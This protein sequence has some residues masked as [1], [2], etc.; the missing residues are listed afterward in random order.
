MPITFLLSLLGGIL[1][2]KVSQ[3]VFYV[4]FFLII[5]ITILN[6]QTRAMIPDIN[7]NYLT[8]HVSL[9]T[10]EAE[11][12]QPA[13]PKW[14]NISQL[15]IKDIPK[16]HIEIISG[17][18]SIKE[19]KRTPTEHEYILDAKTKLSIGE[20]TLYF[21]GWNLYVNGKKQPIFIRNNPQGTIGFAATQGIHD[22]VLKF[23]D[24]PIRRF[25][26][27]LTILGVILLMAIVMK[28]HGLTPVVSSSFKRLKSLVL[29]LFGTIFIHELT[30][31]V[32][33][34]VAI[35]GKTK[36]KYAS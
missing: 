4:F 29:T 27:Y 24:T 21:P 32:L 35:K 11:G 23:E 31:M 10:Y 25:S 30:L 26:K 13:A 28:L 34:L 1:F 2:L 9:S 20:N 18:G 12:L 8:D 6:W 17:N 14:T 5:G 22:I 33:R 36:Q 3:K 16:R 7:D 15:W 19:I